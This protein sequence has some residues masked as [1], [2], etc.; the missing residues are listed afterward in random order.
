MR[1]KG[2][3]KVDDRGKEYEAFKSIEKLIFDMNHTVDAAVVEGPHD[4][5]T[6]RLMGYKRPIIPCSKL[7]PSRIVD[8]IAKRYMI[9]VV[10]TDFDSKGEVMGERLESLL[11][12]RGVR[13]D[14]SS[15]RHFRRL[16]RRIDLDTIEGIYRLKMKLF[17]SNRSH[18][19]SSHDLD[20]SAGCRFT[21]TYTFTSIVDR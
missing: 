17:H 15:R 10:L 4:M 18:H 12:D 1:E 21:S 19:N 14:R 9:V 7:S 11:K 13:V 2:T 3:S 6:L 16:L 5:K 8:Q 20:C